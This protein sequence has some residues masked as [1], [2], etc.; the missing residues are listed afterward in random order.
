MC[1]R[2]KERVCGGGGGGWGDGRGGGGG[3]GGGV[4]GGGG[5]RGMGGAEE[6]IG[7]FSVICRLLLRVGQKREKN[8]NVEVCE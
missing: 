6:N 8:Q 1:V 2:E 5:E 7:L 4:G 3:G